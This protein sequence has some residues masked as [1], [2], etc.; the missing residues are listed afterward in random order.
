MSVSIKMISNVDQNHF[1]MHRSF[2]PGTPVVGI[3][4]TDI[5]ARV[6]GQM[7]TKKVTRHM[8]EQRLLE[9]GSQH[10]LQPPPVVHPEGMEKS[11]ILALDS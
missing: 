2:D 4:P 5:T 1:K 6:H 10:P 8:S 9:P 7:W 3:C 11:K